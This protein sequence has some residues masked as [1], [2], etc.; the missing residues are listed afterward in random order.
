MKLIKKKTDKTDSLNIELLKSEYYDK[1][2]DDGISDGDY[3]ARIE[4]A[5]NLLKTK[6]SKH[7]ILKVTGVSPKIL[8]DLSS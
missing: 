6:L 4:V 3:D 7:E 5:K 1:G 8:K 2:Y